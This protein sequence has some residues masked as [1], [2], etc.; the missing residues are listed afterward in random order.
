MSSRF[1][2]Q[3][4]NEPRFAH[5]D[6]SPPR[7]DD[8]RSSV[9]HG[10]QT[11]PR[12]TEPSFRST[13]THGYSGP[14]RDALKEPPRGPKALIDPPRG[15][16]F[17]SRG[18]GYGGRGESRDREFRDVR[19]APFARRESD[20]DWVRRDQFEG[21]DLRTSPAG[22]ARS[23]SPIPRTF[24]DT[25]DL[26]PRDLDLTRPRRDSRD[27]RDGP[28]SAP[29]V[30]DASMP[31]GY[32]S[33]GAFRGRARADWDYRGR[34]RGGLLDDRDNLGPRNQS[35]DNTWLRDVHE[36]RS[37]DREKDVDRLEDSSKQLR[38]DLDQE[39]D[40]YRHAH[41]PDSRN[42]G[43]IHT[44]ASTPQS[45]SASSAHQSTAEQAPF[46]SFGQAPEHPRRQS[47]AGHSSAPFSSSRDEV[48]A[49]PQNSRVEVFNDRHVPDIPSSPPQ[50][51]PVPA[52][53]SIVHRPSSI[54][55]STLTSPH[56][57]KEGHIPKPGPI[58]DSDNSI[59]AVPT[60]PKAQ[61]IGQP[62]FGPRAGPPFERRWPLDISG[63]PNRGYEG[64][65]RDARSNNKMSVSAVASPSVNRFA[66][67]QTSLSS[68]VQQLV[69]GQ[70]AAPS[71]RQSG[72]DTIKPNPQVSYDGPSR[73]NQSSAIPGSRTTLP[74]S[75]VSAQTQPVRIPTGPRASSQLGTARG[76]EA[77]S[78]VPR[79]PAHPNLQWVAPG[80]REKPRGPSIMNTMP[81]TVSVPS[82]RDFSGHDRTAGT[83]ANR[84]NRKPDDV[85]GKVVETLA[86]PQPRDDDPQDKMSS[87]EGLGVQGELVLDTSQSQ[88]SGFAISTENIQVSPEEHDA[89]EDE[90]SMDL[91]EADLEDAERKFNRDMEAWEAKRP[92]TPRH[93]AELLPLL[94]ELDALASA[95]EDLARGIV[96]SSSLAD[97]SN[98]LQQELGL[99]SPG[100][101]ETDAVYAEEDRSPPVLDA[102]R[103]RIDT[104]P[105]ES[106]PFLVSG[107]P[108]PFSELSILDETSERHT[109]VVSHV[110]TQL[111]L[112]REQ[113]SNDY[114]ELRDSYASLYKPWRLKVEDLDKKKSA[115]SVATASPTSPQ[116]ATPAKLNQGPVIEA[117]RTGRLYASEFEY[118]QV[119][120]ESALALEVQ[121]EQNDREAK[122]AD[123]RKEATI[124]E[125]LDV[126]KMRSSLFQDV[127][128]FIDSQLALDVLAF[129]PPADNFTPE[130]HEVFKKEYGNYP[131]KWGRIAD[132]IP[133]RDY[134]DCI[135]HY[136]LTKRDQSYKSLLYKKAGRKGR[137]VTRGSQMRPK[138]NA[139]ISDLGTRAQMRDGNDFESTQGAV[140]DRGRPR[141]AAAPTF[142]E[143]QGELE[144]P[145]PI[146]V[147]NRRG[148]A[149]AAKADANGEPIPEKPAGRRGRQAQPKG[150]AGSKRGKA[151]L[152]AAAPGPSPQKKD[153]E[154]RGKSKEPKIEEEQKLKEMEEAQLLADLHTSQ[155]APIMLPQQAYTDTQNWLGGPRMSIA[156]PLQGIR[157]QQQPPPQHQQ[158]QVLEQP[159]QQQQTKG[160][161]QTS[162]YWSVPEQQEFHNLVSH[163][164]TDWQAIA[165][166][167]KSKTHI[168]V[169]HLLFPKLGSQRELGAN[170]GVNQVKNY[171]FRSLEQGKTDIEAA[172]M[173]ADAKRKRGEDMGPPPP[174]TIVPKRRYDTGP[175]MM[176]HRPL[177]PSTDVS[178]TENSTSKL[179]SAATQGSPPH[180]T[181]A[182]PRFPPLAQAAPVHNLG[183]THQTPQ[184][185][186]SPVARGQPSVSGP[187][188]THPLQG[189][190][191]GYFP[192]ERKEA[193][194]SLQASPATHQMHPQSVTIQQQPTPTQSAPQQITQQLPQQLTLQVQQHPKPVEQQVQQ[195]QQHQQLQEQERAFQSALAQQ[196]ERQHVVRYQQEPQQAAQ[197]ASNHYQQSAALV[198]QASNH[199]P[200]PAT[201]AQQSL[202][203][204]SQP[205]QAAQSSAPPVRIA[206]SQP[207]DPDRRSLLES[208]PQQQSVE[209]PTTNMRRL[210]SSGPQALG[211]SHLQSPAT[212]NMR[213]PVIMSPPHESARPSSVPTNTPTQ[214]PNRPPPPPAKRSNIMSILN[215]EPADPQPRKRL[216]EP[217]AAVP[218]PPPQ[219]PATP[220]QM[221]QPAAQ[222]IPSFHRRDTQSEILHPSLPNQRAPYGQQVQQQPQPP[223][224]AP[225]PREA[226]SNNWPPTIQRSYYEQRANYQTHTT[227]SPQLQPTYAPVPRPSY[228]PLQP[229]HAPSP[230]PHPQLRSSSYSSLPPQKQATAN[231]TTQALQPSP[232]TQ[233]QPPH[234]APP[235][236]TQHMPPQSQPPSQ[237]QR[238]GSSYAS[239]TYDHYVR[240]EETFHPQHQDAYRHQEAMRQH[241]AYRQQDGLRQQDVLRQEQMRREGEAR[242]YTPP[243]YS[244][245]PPPYQPRQQPPPQH[246]Q[247]LQR[248]EEQ[249]YAQRK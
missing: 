215:D 7:F 11:A 143:A 144:S 227:Q 12:I 50:A 245:Q 126:N 65:A 73:H 45:A 123:L 225:Q 147:S 82:K 154:G 186:T 94:E 124:P 64:D 248:D 174:P 221:Y 28:P 193:R 130:E 108:T 137:K 167:M 187:R 146:T 16:G 9:P 145:V 231:Q 132:A 69:S 211:Q 83:N 81:P 168:M 163:F 2:P 184:N 240:R 39:L 86:R 166:H 180:Y 122:G 27:P 88:R 133:G 223:Q 72:L 129:V 57:N 25:R 24:R 249:S 210:D 192:D 236:S 229:T 149:P 89:S 10:G 179:Q 158:L 136:Y 41:R 209:P 157:T 115:E 77:P 228:Q 176:P 91:D 90:D 113:V 140:T 92:A 106:L 98:K 85:F 151:P 204:R 213:P 35:R 31:G 52:F 195:A 33:R 79:I 125:M 100:L 118:E 42:S 138:S 114:E 74:A 109:K 178:D 159:M 234:H 61:L 67:S 112:Q 8:R 75:E 97:E 131:K 93:H 212:G 207:T 224:Q 242:T 238:Q 155:A 233:I 201:L 20:R 183:P 216:S 203:Q 185:D 1:P 87:S 194:P 243:I 189:P 40:R 181:Q 70:S 214:P 190:R 134:Q 117:R 177:A 44:G 116:P 208:H 80:L 175:Q 68:P 165:N 171:Y 54:S 43:S 110:F 220:S 26:P 205:N 162:S 32:F 161:T 38:E 103:K 30:P 182:P 148:A 206:S 105:I 135:L 217:R 120:R 121:K 49:D 197:Q 56:T 34:G 66:S 226:A 29:S 232:Y 76:F 63:S 119:L 6:R 127:N 22:R 244:G 58:L 173:Q 142:G 84:I 128:G 62:P 3:T 200:Q 96:S 47:F 19:D 188:A 48:R 139:L 235:S 230:P 199:Y 202:G 15:A 59:K 111:A 107:P 60:A 196:H 160:Q 4:T 99:P 37:G 14:G 102:N 239:P 172:A 13:E 152:L 191:A 18:R 222:T 46:R 5:R 51:P 95:A 246:L 153:P 71:L 170:R 164:G 104:P 23:R 218:T 150:A 21:R 156:A 101:E 219:S 198:Q 78:K 237:H 55:Q 36:D 17:M 247:Q 241:D 141:R 53:G 169:H